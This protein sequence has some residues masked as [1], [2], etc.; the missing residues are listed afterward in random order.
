MATA[1][2]TL[3]KEVKGLEESLA[4]RVLDYIR[5]LRDGA[6]LEI[7]AEASGAAEAERRLESEKPVSYRSVRKNLGIA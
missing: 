2:D 3:M 5:G 7:E 6:A 4:V 1:K